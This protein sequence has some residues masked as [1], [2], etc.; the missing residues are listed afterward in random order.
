MPSST[1]LYNLEHA[2][3]EINHTMVPSN[4]T[5]YSAESRDTA[6]IQRVRGAGGYAERVPA[7]L[8]VDVGSGLPG[9][10]PA[11]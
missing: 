1:H 6:P 5:I 2:M 9:N 4:G 7:S 10:Y 11:Q 3:I 8:A